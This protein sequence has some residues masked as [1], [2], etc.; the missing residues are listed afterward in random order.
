MIVE[1]LWGFLITCVLFVLPLY[2]IIGWEN[3]SPLWSRIRRKRNLTGG[4]R[5]PPPPVVLTKN[6]IIAMAQRDIYKLNDNVACPK[7]GVDIEQMYE[8]KQ[9]ARQIITRSCVRLDRNQPNVVF[10]SE[11]VNNFCDEIEKM[12]DEYKVRV[13]VFFQ[14]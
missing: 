7:A 6:M 8:D 4:K 1:I 12:M 14:R 5:L 9:W 3:R 2:A 13:M 10:L 11:A